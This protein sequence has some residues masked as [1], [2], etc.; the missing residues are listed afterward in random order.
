MSPHRLFSY[1]PNQKLDAFNMYVYRAI[2]ICSVQKLLKVKLNFINI[3][4]ETWYDYGNFSWLNKTGVTHHPSYH[5]Q[6]KYVAFVR[7]FSNGIINSIYNKLIKGIKC[8]VNPVL[9]SNLIILP[10]FR[11]FGHQNSQILIK[12]NFKVI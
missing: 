1:L 7:E 2:N 5:W 3:P 10:Y 4:L 9:I 8:S 6:V 12:Y 11:K